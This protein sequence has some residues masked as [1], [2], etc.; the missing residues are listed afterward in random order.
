MD[1]FARALVF[2]EIQ[3]YISRQYD[4]KNNTYN[5]GNEGSRAFA[6]ASATDSAIQP[7]AIE[8]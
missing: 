5:F 1:G 7:L 2:I 3:I 8:T 6:K 4:G